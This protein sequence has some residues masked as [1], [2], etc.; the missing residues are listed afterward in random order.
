MK[1]RYILNPFHLN[2]GPRS[3]LEIAKAEYKNR[4]PN[5]EVNLRNPFAFCII[6][7]VINPDKTLR[8]DFTF[9]QDIPLSMEV[10]SKRPKGFKP[11]EQV[12]N[13]DIREITK[14]IIPPYKSKYY[15]DFILYVLDITTDNYWA[16]NLW[17]RTVCPDLR[18]Y[19]SKE[20]KREYQ[21]ISLRI[22][23]SYTRTFILGHVNLKK[24]KFKSSPG[25]TKLIK[26][27][28]IPTI[29]LLPQ[30]FGEMVRIIELKND[31]AQINSFVI[32]SFNTNFLN[33]I[34]ARWMEASLVHKRKEIFLKAFEAY[35]RDDFYS[36][37]YILFPQI[38]GLITE[39]IKRK[40]QLPKPSPKDRFYQFGEIIKSEKF[41]TEMTRYLTDVLISNLTE[42]FYKTWY[43]YPK[44]GKIYKQPTIS[45]QRHVL[46]HGE[47]NPRY[48][49]QENC[50]KLIC[51]LDAI[52][53]LSLQK[54]DLP[55][56]K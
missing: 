36:T 47:V 33:D 14:I 20:R 13:I 18:Y 9:P 11:G 10:I 24:G 12:R 23:K 35:Q 54:N 50:I 48:F 39:H 26:H 34:L 42:A 53:L 3:L 38:E 29:S 31:I 6:Y 7:L 51:I 2:I 49:T 17:T 28:W 19:L 55:P 21:E 44:K 32:S 52:I 37:V 56:A 41:N 46:M 45:P 27:G 5:I 1:R 16:T 8:I 40:R 30:P 4:Y 15:F 43:P 25:I 22:A